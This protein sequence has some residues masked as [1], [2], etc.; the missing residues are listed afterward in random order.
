MSTLTQILVF[1][2][3]KDSHFTL[4]GL[5]MLTKAKNI[6]LQNKLGSVR[7]AEK[8]GQLFK[9]SRVNGCVK[10]GRGVGIIK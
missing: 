1:Q 6:L 9:I 4:K 5:H 10:G 7:L 2:F 3:G 8:I